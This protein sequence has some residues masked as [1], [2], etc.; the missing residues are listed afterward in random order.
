MAFFVLRSGGTKLLNILP[1][2]SVSEAAAAVSTSSS[3]LY[4]LSGIF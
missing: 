2:C 4:K 1:E 3:T